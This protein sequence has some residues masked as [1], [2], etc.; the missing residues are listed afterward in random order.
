MRRIATLFVALTMLIGAFSV[1]VSAQT[2]LSVKYVPKTQRGTMFYLDLFSE[3]PIGAA[4]FDIGYDDDVAEFRGVYCDSAD[5]AAEAHAENSMIGLAYSNRKP[6]SGKLFR[7]SFIALKSGTINF[8]VTVTQAVDSEL[9][10][11]SDIPACHLSVELGKK[12]IPA[13]SANS[14]KVSGKTTTSKKS[15]SGSKSNITVSSGDGDNKAADS[16]EAEGISLDLSGQNK[17]TF[18]L[19]GGAAAFLVCL[20]IVAAYFLGKRRR[21]K[22][23]QEEEIPA[24]Q[25]E[26]IGDDAHE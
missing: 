14:A 17:T 21:E 26:D 3:L 23:P 25:D 2:P 12:D 11:L 4:V 1:S 19:L 5:A 13:S 24:A 10:Y 7:L 9:S 16:A 22:I 8:A 15:Y 6:S 18:F 20:L